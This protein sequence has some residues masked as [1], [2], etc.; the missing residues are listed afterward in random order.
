MLHL[1]P[2]VIALSLMVASV[3]E[4][5]T[6]HF[7][8]EAL[9]AVERIQSSAPPASLY[10]EF[11]NIMDTM[12]KA[13]DL[14]EQD[15]IVEAENLYRL[16][17]LK[18]S[19]YEEKVHAWQQAYQEPVRTKA[20]VIGDPAGLMSERGGAPDQAIHPGPAAEKVPVKDTDPEK[21]IADIEDETDGEPAQSPMIIGRKTN[22]TVRKGDSLRMIGAKFG[23]DWRVI[24][25]DNGIAPGTGV[26][27][28][29]KLLINTTRIIPK[30]MAEGIVINIPDRTLYLFKGKKLEKALPVGLGMNKSGDASIW[31]TP[32]GKFKIISKVKDPTWFVPPS[33]QSEMRRKG[34][35]VKTVVPPGNR[36]PLGKYAL[37]TSLSG[38]LIH[39]T[40]FPQSIYGFSSHGCIRVMPGNM[41]EIYKEVRVNTGGEI[42]YQPVKVARTDDGRIFL[43]VHGD[44]YGRYKDLENVAKELIVKMNA[45]R[46]VDWERV[47]SLVKSRSGIA[48]DI[49]VRAPYRPL[50]TGKY[51][52]DTG[53]A[54]R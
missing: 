23:A 54:M 13:E 5:G 3:C 12:A 51:D 25:R 31:K 49:S 36:N 11:G 35:T 1:L 16:T 17:L 41:E 47:R 19:L 15:K 2:A 53:I 27:P 30:V 24:A 46:E 34:R 8:E 10:E 18:S 7:R 21:P 44:V 39:G 40:I 43:E 9:S 52:G 42:I 38:I 26:K 4:A 45:Q 48:E 22:Y 50:R 14:L 32:T 28:G 29:Q 33:I 37:K 20:G 6:V